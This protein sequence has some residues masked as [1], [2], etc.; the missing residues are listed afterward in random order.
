MAA[1]QLI[2]DI[3]RGL[4]NWYPFKANADILYISDKED[5]LSDMLKEQGHK[6][7]VKTYQEINTAGFLDEKAD[8]FHML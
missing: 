1:K 7:L 5:C 8:F 6:V 3:Q 4:L 2:E